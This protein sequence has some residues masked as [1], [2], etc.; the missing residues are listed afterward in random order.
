MQVVWKAAFFD[1]TGYGT[2][3]RGFALSLDRIGVNIRLIQ[4]GRGSPDK[5]PSEIRESI[6][7]LMQRK[8]EEPSKTFF[9]RHSIPN[10][11]EKEGFFSMGV[12]AWETSG[13]HRLW[14]DWCNGMD[15]VGVPSRMNI[16]S[17]AGAG[18]Y[19]PVELLRYGVDECYL[20]PGEHRDPLDDIKTPPF[21]FLS[22]F[23]WIYRKGY[24]VLIRAFGEEFSRDDGVCLVIK[25]GFGGSRALNE[26]IGGEMQR[27]KNMYW[28]GNSPPV[29]LLTKEMTTEKLVSLY[30]SCQCFVLPSRGEGAGLPLLEAGSLGLPVISTGWGGQTDFLD[31]YNSLLVEFS[32]RPVPVQSHCPYYLPDQKWAE[33]STEDLRAKMRWVRENYGLA[34]EK[35]ALLRGL[36]NKEYTWEKAA[37]DVVAALEK[38]T[39]RIVL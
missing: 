38:L 31:Q 5:I 13:I 8:P 2:A 35:G 11:F 34:L 36:V 7:R 16:A 3:A 17:F 9:V 22:V 27:L 30:R 21:R 20:H 19:K 18:V 12:T 25:T 33:P 23:D 26:T 32:L 14:R 6:L 4:A 24:D 28:K 39:G 15:A 10:L 37:L 29:Y 1:I